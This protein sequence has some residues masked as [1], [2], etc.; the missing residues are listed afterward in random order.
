MAW[1]ATDDPEL[2]EEYARVYAQ[3]LRKTGNHVLL[4]PVV[5]INYNFNNPLVNTR[6]MSDSADHFYYY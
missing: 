4:G 3:M 5:D 6:A 1:G 2:M